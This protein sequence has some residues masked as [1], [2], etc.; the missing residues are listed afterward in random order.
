MIHLDHFRVLI[1]ALLFFIS[2]FGYSY[3]TC[4]DFNDFNVQDKLRSDNSIQIHDALSFLKKDNSVCSF[5]LLVDLWER[6]DEYKY[7]KFSWRR[8][9]SDENKLG[10]ASSIQEK[11]MYGYVYDLGEIRE[12]AEGKA[13]AYNSSDFELI[14][15]AVI[16][17][18][19]NDKSAL[20]KLKNIALKYKDNLNLYKMY[21]TIISYMCVKG[22][23]DYTNMLISKIPSGDEK[24]EIRRQSQEG[25]ESVKDTCASMRKRGEVE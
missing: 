22:V 3:E 23:G 14:I 17:G 25:I 5:E 19:F 9:H 13:S 11:L 24:E 8:I 2:G 15:S 18:R 16:L 4:S 6:S 21:I 7:K 20:N 12:F 10:I 1:I